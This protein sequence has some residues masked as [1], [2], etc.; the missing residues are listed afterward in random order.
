[1]S[2]DAVECLRIRWCKVSSSLG[3]NLMTFVCLTGDSS[4]GGHVTR[5]GT[6]RKGEDRSC[7]KPEH[8]KI[9]HSLYIFAQKWI[10]V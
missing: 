2:F 10:I 8:D 7:E 4:A 1:M 9:G 5:S 3:K 6:I